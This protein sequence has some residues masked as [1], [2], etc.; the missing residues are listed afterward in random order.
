MSPCFFAPVPPVQFQLFW[1]NVLFPNCGLHFREKYNFTILILSLLLPLRDVILYWQRSLK[2]NARNVAVNILI[3]ERCSHTAFSLVHTTVYLKWKRRRQDW[4]T[5]AVDDI[6]LIIIICQSIFVPTEE[7]PKTAWLNWQSD[8]FFCLCFVCF[9]V[10]FCFDKLLAP[11]CVR[12]GV[13]ECVV[14][15]ECLTCSGWNMFVNT[16]FKCCCC[17]TPMCMLAVPNSLPTQLI[18]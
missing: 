18:F 14:L 9:F 1:S 17:F 10:G 11:V 12:E 15:C 13:C 3:Y 4:L 8:C 5:S 2:K 16:F 6:I 7:Y